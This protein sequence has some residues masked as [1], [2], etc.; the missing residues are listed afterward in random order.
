MKK[1]S[2]KEIE[3]LNALLLELQEPLTFD[4]PKKINLFER[5]TNLFKKKKLAQQLPPIVYKIKP[6]IEKY[7]KLV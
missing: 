4:K 7:T 2:G 3:F 1:F 6:Y 5:L